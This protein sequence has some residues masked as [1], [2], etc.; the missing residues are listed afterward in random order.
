MRFEEEKSKRKNLNRT[1]NQATDNFNWEPISNLILKTRY[2]NFSKILSRI[3]LNY[4]ENSRK[5]LQL[6]PKEMSKLLQHKEK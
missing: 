2:K 1:S 3:N 5:L 4:V 6:Y